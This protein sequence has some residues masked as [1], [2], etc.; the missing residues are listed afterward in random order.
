VLD[1]I[2]NRRDAY[3]AVRI[4]DLSDED[5]ELLSKAIPILERLAEETVDLDVE[6][7]PT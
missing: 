7:V 2:R 4:R 3:L 6:S 1:E 5:R